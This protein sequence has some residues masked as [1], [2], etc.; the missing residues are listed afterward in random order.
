M[1]QATPILLAADFARLKQE[2]RYTERI[3]REKQR[4]RD[5]EEIENPK[6]RSSGNKECHYDRAIN[7]L[8][9]VSVDNKEENRFTDF[10]K[11]NRPTLADGSY[12]LILTYEHIRNGTYELAYETEPLT[13]KL[14]DDLYE[15][16]AKRM[17]VKRL[18]YGALGRLRHIS[19]RA[20]PEVG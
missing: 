12:Y 5:R 7:N 16:N 8:Q 10:L 15:A 17:L 20:L 6:P 18:Y 2:E 19:I 11:S 4:K 9:F 14:I 3:E 1:L 13:D